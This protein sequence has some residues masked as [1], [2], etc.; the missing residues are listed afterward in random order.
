MHSSALLRSSLVL[1]VV[2][3]DTARTVVA[4]LTGLFYWGL[5][6]V[7]IN[8]YGKRQNLVLVYSQ[9]PDALYTCICTLS[10]A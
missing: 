9:H 1:A 4:V 5:P 10:T 8:I 3:F 2:I 7:Y 6:L